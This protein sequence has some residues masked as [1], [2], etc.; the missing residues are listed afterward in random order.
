MF[1]LNLLLSILFLMLSTRSRWPGVMGSMR[2]GARRA[3]ILILDPPRLWSRTQYSI[4][5]GLRSSRYCQ[6]CLC[7]HVEVVMEGGVL[8]ERSLSPNS[9]HRCCLPLHIW[10]TS[11]P[12]AAPVFLLPDCAATHPWSKTVVSHLGCC[13]GFLTGLPDLPMPCSCSDP[14]QHSP[15]T[16]HLCSNPPLTPPILR[17]SKVSLTYNAC[18]ALHSLLH[19]SPPWLSSSP[20][21][22]P[23]APFSHVGQLAIP[24]THQTDFYL[25]PFALP[26]PSAW[27]AF[28]SDISIVHSHFLR[29]EFSPTPF[30]IVSPPNPLYPLSSHFSF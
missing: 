23:L 14:S 30:K 7:W 24:W 20:T 28:L 22:F 12:A 4:P 11:E 18:K 15:S 5:P 21:A 9:W 3:C 6:Q 1:Y 8:S 17:L 2:S 25:R 27:I 16:S 26:V 10:S 19:P 13:G 29:E